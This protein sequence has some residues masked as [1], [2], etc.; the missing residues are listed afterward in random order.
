MYTS[1]QRPGELFYRQDVDEEEPPTKIARL[2]QRGESCVMSCECKRK[3]E[4]EERES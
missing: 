4:C 2:L 1:V 3:L